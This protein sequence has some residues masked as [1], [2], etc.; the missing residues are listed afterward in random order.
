MLTGGTVQFYLWNIIVFKHKHSLFL[1]SSR[2]VK[3]KQQCGAHCSAAAAVHV[4]ACACL[5]FSTLFF[6]IIEI[7]SW[8][9]YFGLFVNRLRLNWNK[10]VINASKK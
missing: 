8:C 3:A 7:I 10:K 4:H 5:T 2:A 6:L 1:F 9:C